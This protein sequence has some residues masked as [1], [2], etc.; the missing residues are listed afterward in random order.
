MNIQTIVID[1]G[2]DGKEIFDIPKAEGI[3]SAE[4][5]RLVKRVV[6]CMPL[7]EASEMIGEV[8]RDFGFDLNAVNGVIAEADKVAMPEFDFTFTEKITRKEHVFRIRRDFSET[9]QDYVRFLEVMGGRDMNSLNS[10]L[11]KIFE[12]TGVRHSF[13]I[14]R[15]L[16]FAAYAISVVTNGRRPG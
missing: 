15:R 9:V 11:K 7:D 3:R 10:I 2:I 14:Q 1:C 8:A 16:Q 6:G 5:R 12:R 4:F 13:E